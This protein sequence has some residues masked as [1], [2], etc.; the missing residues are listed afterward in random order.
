M[1]KT[2]M[3]YV[4][5]SMVVLGLVFFFY[6]RRTE[7]STDFLVNHQPDP[8]TPNLQIRLEETVE[9]RA[10][11]NQEFQTVKTSHDVR[12]LYE[13]YMDVIG[14]NGIFHELKALK[15]KCHGEG[16]PLG[17]VIYAK[18][19]RMGP[20]LE[21]CEGGCY[22]GCM[23]G[24]FMELFKIDEDKHEHTAGSVKDRDRTIL[25]TV[26]ENIPDICYGETADLYKPGDCAH[27][28]GH[29]V[30]YILDYDIPRT[31][32]HCRLFD[33]YAMEYYCATGGY[34][35]Y[36]NTHDREDRKKQ[37]LL[38]PCDT[39][40]Y[41]AACF[42]YKLVH[43]FQRHYAERKDLNVIVEK[44]MGLTGKYRLGCFHGIGN[45]HMF[46]IAKRSV[47]FQQICQFGTKQDQYMCIE[48]AVERMAKYHPEQAVQKCQELSGWRYEL[49]LSGTQR[50]MYDLDKSFEYYVQ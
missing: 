14:A 15:P 16:H 34:M 23:H 45:A 24:V 17:M 18:L 47:S 44:C 5:I 9:E 13:K 27:A 10:R 6:T 37:P 22:S 21:A 28:V 32:E 36:V 26:K 46:Y 42:R 48:G 20:A 29:A 1:K 3:F 2:L 39:G 41:P 11:F 35:E 33:T 43:V 25:S 38:Y 7:E 19:G 12:M 49:C 8:V 50:R 40:E 31:M 30:M 4:F